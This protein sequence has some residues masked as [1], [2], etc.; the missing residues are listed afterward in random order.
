MAGSNG[1]QVGGLPVNKIPWWQS[2]IVWAG[3]VVV[4]LI[5]GAVAMAVRFYKR[6]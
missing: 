6:R 4:V 3:I 5:A 2:T 1:R